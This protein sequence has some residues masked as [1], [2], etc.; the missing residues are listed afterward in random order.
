MNLR[1]PKML[2]NSGVAA[3]LT[4]SQEGLSSMK[5][6]SQLVVGITGNSDNWIK[7]LSTKTQL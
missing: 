6:V 4:A 7:F 5:L 2:E 1:V 3:Q